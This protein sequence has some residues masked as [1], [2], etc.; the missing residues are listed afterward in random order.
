MNKEERRKN[1]TSLHV[2][3]HGYSFVPCLWIFLAEIRLCA[4][5]AMALEITKS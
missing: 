3:S 4:R 2:P 5:A 1:E